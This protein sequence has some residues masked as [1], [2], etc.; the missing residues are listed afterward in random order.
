MSAPIRVESKRYFAALGSQIASL[1]K[2]QGFSQAELARAVGVSQQALFAYEWGYRRVSVLI[3]AKIANVFRVPVV[4]LIGL[5]PAC[6][7]G[8]LSPKAIRHAERLQSL[9]RT[10]QR[11][12]VRIIDVLEAAKES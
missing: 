12:V 7:K 9:T 5:T 2:A 11:F 6:R 10:Q 4:E 1:R 8:R 3:L